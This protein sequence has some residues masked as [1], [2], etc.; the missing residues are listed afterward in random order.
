MIALQW[1]GVVLE[2]LREKIALSNAVRDAYS[3]LAT[4]TRTG[5][6]FKLA[7]VRGEGRISVAIFGRFGHALVDGPEQLAVGYS[8]I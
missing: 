8:V 5:G 4:V 1:R 7:A 3:Q 6:G 2:V